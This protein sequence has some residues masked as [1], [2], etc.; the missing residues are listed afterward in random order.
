MK[1]I[2]ALFFASVMSLTATAQDI[3]KVKVTELAAAIAES[4]T[5][6]IVNFWATFCIPCLEEIPYFLKAAEQYKSDSVQL[7]LVS[8]DLEESYPAKLKTFVAKRNY[9]APVQWLDEYNADY[10]IPKIDTAWSGAIPASLFINNKTGFRRFLE[11]QVSP[12]ML[13][14]VIKEMLQSKGKGN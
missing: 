10:F 7:L 2:I 1:F 9:T 14:A 3:K 12:G 8:L 11:E 4:K 13:D 6:L 5:P